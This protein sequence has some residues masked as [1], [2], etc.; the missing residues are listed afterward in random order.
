MKYRLAIF[1][2]DGTIL[3][4]LDDLCDSVNFALYAFSMP[5]RTLDEVRAFVGNGIMKLIERAVPEN[6]SLSTIEAVYETFCEHY[7]MNSANKTK[8]Y[9]GVVELL[10]QLKENGVKLAVLSNKA[11]FAVSVLCELYFKGLFDYVAGEKQGIP[12]KPAPDAVF[13]ILQYFDIDASQAVYIGD[14]DVDFLTAKN[15]GLDCI[16]VSWGFRSKELL[17]NLGADRIVDDTYE[18][19]RYLE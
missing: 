1:D 4:T 12:R 19:L 11:D 10:M 2:L 8:P 15:S 18:L 16:L 13:N 3:N 17:R 9:S 7:K 6:T 5:L 14:S